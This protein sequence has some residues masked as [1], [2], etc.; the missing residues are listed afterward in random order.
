MQLPP[1]FFEIAERLADVRGVVI[2]GVAMVA[3]GSAHLTSDYDLV[4][5]RSDANIKRLAQALLPLKARLR[6]VPDDVPFRL[7]WLTLRGGLNFTLETELGDVDLLGHAAGAPPYPEL[8][9][10]AMEV[11]LGN[12]TVKVASLE[13]L[14]A[15]KRAANRPKDQNHLLELLAL[16]KLMEEEPQ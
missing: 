12:V 3:H 15:M 16:K 1:Q 7:D 2:G 13:D 4:Y 5:E 8:E 14:I 10:R 6:G 9:A 11:Y